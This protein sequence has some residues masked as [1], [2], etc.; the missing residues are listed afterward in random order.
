[1]TAKTLCETC[2]FRRNG[3]QLKR[4]RGRLDEIRRNALE[5]HMHVCHS[6]GLDENS[7]PIRHCAGAI[8]YV[9]R[10]KSTTISK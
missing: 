1:M 7:N 2:V 3:N 6:F 4:P 8:R 5:G 9:A 10:S